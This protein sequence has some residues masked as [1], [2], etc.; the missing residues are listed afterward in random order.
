MIKSLTSL[1][2]VFILFIFFHHCMNMYPGGGSMAVSFFFI[3]SGFSMTLGYKDK[4]LRPDF[5]YKH[6]FLRRCIKFYPLHWL[7]L[8]AVLPL[9]L[10]PFHINKGLFFLS[11]ATLTQTLVP[12]KPFYFSFNAVS[13]YLADT[14]FFAALFPI[15]LRSIL[16]A[17]RKHFGVVGVL[18]LVVYI[19]L[20][21]L[22][23]KEEYHSILYISPYI[24][25]TD[26]VFGIILALGYLKLNKQ[27]RIQSFIN[28][29]SAM[30]HIVVTAIIVFLI[31][32]SCL[33]SNDWRLVAPVY[34]IPIGILL[35]ICSLLTENQGV[36]NVGKLYDNR[37][38]EWLGKL[39]FTIFLT[40][41]VVLRYVTLIFNHYQ[42]EQ[43][44]LF[45]ILSLS[46]SLTISFLVEQYFLNPFTQ[47]LTKKILPSTIAQ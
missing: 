6:Y 42:F 34:W 28:Q 43:P 39:S 45:V 22:L 13:W 26:F 47:W 21:T 32:E 17:K 1:R 29:N 27:T 24:R 37:L 5:S 2:G 12:L 14:L 31:V 30:F 44:V 20:V 23:P 9:D 38:F 40:H 18:I 36:S 25:I 35:L 15:L 41:L 46:L 7:C 16:K 10:L 4:V 11:N 19:T 33:L 3:L 8:L